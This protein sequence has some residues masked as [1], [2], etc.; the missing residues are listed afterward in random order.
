[1]GLFTPAAVAA[2]VAVMVVAAG[3]VHLRNG[4]FAQNGGYE[5]TLVL[6]LGALSLAFTGPGAI[7]LDAALGLELYGPEWGFGGLLLGLTGGGIQLALRQRQVT[8]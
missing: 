1:L 5:Y 6:A 2:L 4:F 3:S 8:A 7:S